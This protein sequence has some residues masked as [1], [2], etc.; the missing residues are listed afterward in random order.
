MHLNTNNTH[1]CSWSVAHVQ[2]PHLHTRTQLTTVRS[3][4]FHVLLQGCMYQFVSNATLPY[5]Q[6]YLGVNGEGYQNLLTVQQCAWAMKGF[7]GSAS[8]IAPIF[9][10]SKTPYLIAFA[11]LGSV[12]CAFLAMLDLRC[13]SEIVHLI[14]IHTPQSGVRVRDKEECVSVCVRVRACRFVYLA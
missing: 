9:G 14:I 4:I 7:I 12:A 10:Y 13:G 11:A 6:R 1:T 3:L 8:D 2:S 5:V